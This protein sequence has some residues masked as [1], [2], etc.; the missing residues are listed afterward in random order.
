M[1]ELEQFL[2]DRAMEHDSPTLLFNLACE[3]LISAKTIHPGVVLLARMVAAA[4]IRHRH[5]HHAAQR[6]HRLREL[7]TRQSLGALD[8]QLAVQR[9]AV[10]TQSQSGGLAVVHWL[11][12]WE[13]DDGLV[14]V[15]VD[16]F[17]GVADGDSRG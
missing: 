11:G 5:R 13:G 7:L 4:R 8:V 3:Y 10:A 12:L 1:K 15:G 6:H 16:A 17:G 9:V 2:L 14:P